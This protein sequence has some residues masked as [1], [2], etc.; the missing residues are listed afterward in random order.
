MA[1]LFKGLFG[2]EL[3]GTSLVNPI[4]TEGSAPPPPEVMAMLIDFD[5][6]PMEQVEAQALVANN[7]DATGGEL[8]GNEEPAFTIV[9][10]GGDSGG[11]EIENGIIIEE[12][13]FIG[14]ATGAFGS[15]GLSKRPGILP[16][17]IDS[18]KTGSHYS[19]FNGVALMLISLHPKFSTHRYAG[20]AIV[21][22]TALFSGSIYL[23]VLQRERFKFMGPVTPMGG[24]SL[25]AGYAMLAL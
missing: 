6:M 2:F 25:L 19:I 5:Q 8:V 7:I 15:H 13:A 1:S 18:W 11:Q 16:G 21:V 14:I 24:L 12:A 10:G 22:G 9:I 17:Q 4:T 20:P 23:L 3:V